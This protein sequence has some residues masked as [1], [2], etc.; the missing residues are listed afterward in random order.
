MARCCF[1]IIAEALS[2]F[3]TAI[4]IKTRRYCRYFKQAVRK[5]FKRAF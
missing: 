2:L 5:S 4:K 1:C 3:L